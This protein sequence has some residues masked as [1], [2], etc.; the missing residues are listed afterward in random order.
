MNGPLW[1]NSKDPP[2]SFH[3]TNPPSSRPARCR[4][5][6][7]E[8]AKFKCNVKENVILIPLTFQNNIVIILSLL[9]VINFPNFFGLISQLI[10]VNYQLIVSYIL[11]PRSKETIFLGE[12]GMNVDPLLATSGVLPLF[13][14]T[15]YK[16]VDEMFRVFI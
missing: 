2:A 8:K 7:T 10:T 6:E 5:A 12:R 4:N 9:Q 15:K 13:K 11:T 14:E 1:G 16:V 3:I